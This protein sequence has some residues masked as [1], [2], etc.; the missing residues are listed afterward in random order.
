MYRA[1]TD[2]LL[3][4]TPIA[5]AV[6]AIVTMGYVVTMTNT[7]YDVVLKI[8]P[9]SHYYAQKIADEYYVQVGEF[10]KEDGAILMRRKLVELSIL[11]FE[12]QRAAE[13]AEKAQQGYEKM[14]SS[15]VS[16]G[17]GPDQVVYARSSHS[18]TK[19]VVGIDLEAGQGDLVST[20][21]EWEKVR[22][23]LNNIKHELKP[24]EPLYIAAAD[25]TSQL[26]AA[27]F[28]FFDSV[29]YERFHGPLGPLATGSQK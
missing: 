18:K 19:W 8:A 11:S 24:E 10:D 29:Q 15:H 20:A 3:N 6:L 12:R 17:Y 23:R 7:L 27:K 26:D 13:N 4:I 16:I 2:G 21:T 22:N 28:E 1:I 5:I 14:L 9:R 25:L